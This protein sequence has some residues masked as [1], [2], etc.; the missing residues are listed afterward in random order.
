[1]LNSLHVKNLALI[2]ET[3]VQFEK[4][5]NILTGETGAGKSVIIGSI[6]LALGAKAD[7]DMIRTG[8]DHALIELVFTLDSDAQREKCAELLLDVED[9]M[10]VISRKIG[11]GKSICRVNGETMTA[12]QL[13]ELAEVLLDVYGQHE[14]QSLTAKRKQLEILDD[15]CGE[16]LA[17]IKEKAAGEY[18]KYARLLK[19]W[20]ALERDDTEREKECALLAFEIGEIDEAALQSGED[21]ALETEYRKMANAR[22]ILEGVTLAR[23]LLSSSEGENVSDMAGRA[24]RELKGIEAY[25]EALCGFTETLSE[26]EGL[27]SDVCRE[28][29]AYEE[30][31]AF[32]PEVF[33][34]TQRRL[35]LL[36]H[37]KSKYGNTVEKVLAYRGEQKKR[38][39]MLNDYDMHVERLKADLEAAREKLLASCRKISRIRKTQAKALEEKMTQALHDLNFLDVTFRIQLSQNPEKAGAGGFDDAEFLISTNPGEPVK[40]LGS[41]ASGGELS[42]IML[43]LKTVM[44]EKDAI[45]TLIFDEIDAGISG[46]TAWQVSKKL[47]WLGRE[48]QI[49]CIT[50]LPQ[51][52]AM[53]DQHFKIE[54]KQEG[55]QTRTDIFLLDETES[56]KELARL[57]GSDLLT[58]AAISNAKE[59]KELA[60]HTKQY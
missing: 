39:D 30:G 21:E 19:E 22:K 15:F 26:I 11:S 37:L 56:T 49:I 59:M 14:H 51:I 12:R 50:H 20:D 48:H 31:L 41:I 13:K 23:C 4:G 44:A 33:D 38:L 29:A 52:A 34:E 3:E 53:A 24:L 42:R 17:G 2:E 54:K 28:L 55:K 18:K 47:A 1:M 35:D 36:N 40:P 10:L 58:D 6:N 9:D 43:G 57:L 8:K 5:L 60:E 45:D 7:K 25:D 16:A 27:V 46:R 32:E